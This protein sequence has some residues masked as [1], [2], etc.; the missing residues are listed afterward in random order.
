MMLCA[1]QLGLLAVDLVAAHKPEIPLN[2]IWKPVEVRRILSSL[3]SMRYD[4]SSGGP[5]RLGQRNLK[6]IALQISTVLPRNYFC[7]L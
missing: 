3:A 4:A 1:R 5:T 7:R 6:Q 2:R